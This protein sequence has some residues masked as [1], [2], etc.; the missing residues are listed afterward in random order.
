M[1]TTIFLSHYHQDKE[2]AQAIANTVARITLG[3]IETWFSND[4]SG[5]GGINPGDVWFN[6]VKS[7][8]ESCSAIIALVTPSSIHRPWIYFES[9]FAAHKGCDVVPLCVGID[10][11]NDLPFPLAMYQAYQLA[12]YDSIKTFFNKLLTKFAIPF[13][14]EMGKPV[15]GRFISEITK[16]LQE[17]PL[18][19]PKNPND[20]IVEQIKEHI[21]RRMIELSQSKKETEKPE[22]HRE[23]TYSVPITIK[24]PNFNVSESLMIS[25]DRSLQSVLDDIFFML[26]PRVKPFTYLVSWILL[27]T[28]RHKRLI[29][30]EIYD[31]LPANV[32]FRHG[33][34]WVALPLDKPYS[35]LDSS[36]SAGL[37]RLIS[38]VEE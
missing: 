13:D 2:I 20:Y 18:D 25:S 28:T 15:L 22:E 35:A 30:K 33:T 16:L 36:T 23:I 19:K 12:H 31:T 29:V 17:N 37:D 5:S 9:G 26:S 3:Q 10:S 8:L 38:H 6:S 1:K 21:D 34:K 4:A 24:F 11:L 27:E 14:E 7:R 32:V